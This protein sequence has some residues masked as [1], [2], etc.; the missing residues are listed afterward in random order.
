MT[1]PVVVVGSGLA[2]YTVAREFRKLNAATPLVVV[3]RDDAA[4]YSKPMLS[5]AL[6]SGKTAASLVTKSA[7]RMA[8]ELDATVLKRT[9]VAAIDVPARRLR[10]EGGRE[11]AWR[12]L[13]LAVGADPVRLPLE[14]DAAAGVLSVNDLDD[15]ARFADRLVGVRRVAI[16]G[17]GLIGCEFAND[18]LSRGISPVVIDIAERPLARLLPDA[19]GGRLR[20]RLEAAGVQFR[21]GLAACSVERDGDG[22]RLTLTDGSTVAADLVLSA[23]GLRPRIGLA[24]AAGLATARGIL[25]DRLLAT[26]APHVHAVGDCAEVEGLWLP[27]VLPLMQQA[28]ALAA[29]LAGTPT[30]VFYPAMPV[31]VKT[32][33]CPAVVCPPPAA[34]GGAWQA[35]MAVDGCEARFHAASGHLL[36]FAVLEAA[37]AH[38]QALAAQLPPWL[39]APASL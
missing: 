7:E 12:D 39:A 30:A 10:L 37:T 32:P 18:L 31:V 2:G 8:A 23:I 20:E 4:F 14:G 38:K 22:V 1:L 13:V 28:R 24:Q 27:F 5:N 21:F 3:S 35:A 9:A 26:S 36:G 11:L 15:Y 33:A 25:V 16:L 17:A 34:A 29:T 19:A 6:A